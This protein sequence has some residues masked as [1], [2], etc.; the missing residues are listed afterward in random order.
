MTHSSH[1][2]VCLV[3]VGILSV[4]GCGDDS[5]GAAGGS[6]AGGGDG[7]VG[8]EGGGASGGGAGGGGD[9]PYGVFS[10]DFL[11]ADYPIPVVPDDNPMSAVK[12]ELG[13]HLFYDKRLSGNETMSCAGCHIQALSFTDGAP[14]ATGSTGQLTPRSSM[15][16]HNVGYFTTYTWG[17]PLIGTLEEQALGPMFGENPVELG[18]SGMDDELLERVRAEPKY[19]EMFP[20]AFPEK[21]DPFDLDAITKAIAAWE[22]T[23]ISYRSP[24]DD[25]VYGGNPD[26]LSD[27]AKQGLALFN[28]DKFDC[29]HCHGGFAF[30]DSVQTDTTVIPEV[31]FHNDALYNIDGMGAYPA[32]NRGVYEITMV[33]TDMGRM[34]AP[35]LRNIEVTAPYMH[36]GSIATLD[37]VLEH[38]AAGGR[39]IVG[40]PNAGVGAD[41][42][43]KSPFVHGFNA[44]QTELDDLKAF[45]LSLTDEAFLTD[46]RYADPWVE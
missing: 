20:L 32:P 27:S 37:E 36:D 24:Y 5:A 33:E 10:W 44:S 7:G 23:I 4:V 39:T 40:G 30:A 28:S 31:F 46:P 3:I 43:Y 34:R 1:W 25:F 19:Q 35:S 2:R 41:N 6:G 13:R 22:R 14:V 9:D 8:A 29:F 26:A 21:D 17:N 42:P 16:L 15:P 12:V 11:P 18:L 45:L 38:Y